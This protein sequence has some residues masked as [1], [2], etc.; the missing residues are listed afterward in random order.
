MSTTQTNRYPDSP[1]SADVPSIE[2]T[3]RRIRNILDVYPAAGWSPGE[4][5]E[6]LKALA[7][8]VRSRQGAVDD[9]RGGNVP[10]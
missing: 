5:Q 1:Q 10:T 7:R 4:A 8:I 3:R 6:V 2:D 9:R